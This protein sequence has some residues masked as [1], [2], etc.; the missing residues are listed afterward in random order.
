M[1][2]QEIKYA[3]EFKL[4]L[5]LVFV[6]NNIAW[7]EERGGDFTMDLPLRYDTEGRTFEITKE[8]ESYW[9]FTEDHGY[10]FVSKDD[11]K[12]LILFLEQTDLGYE[13]QYGKIYN[14]VQSH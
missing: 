1:K 14:I 6:E 3:P 13:I 2:L 12:V 11:N 4:Q 8:S 7:L 10:H 5:D 9:C